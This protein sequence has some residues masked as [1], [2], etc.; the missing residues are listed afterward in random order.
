M[1]EY[2]LHFPLYF[3][4]GRAV[5]GHH[6]E[7]LKKEL[8]SRFGGVTDL[9]HKREG[10]W[11]IGSSLFRDELVVIRVLAPRDEATRSYL[12]EVKARL[13]REL[14]QAQFLIVERPV[15]IL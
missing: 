7:G 6:L 10:L 8:S 3:N 14:E 1:N 12:K 11:K 5:P 9:R 2:D 13:E 4:D 15:E